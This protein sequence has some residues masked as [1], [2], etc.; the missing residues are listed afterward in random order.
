[1]KPINPSPSEP[2][3]I[4]PPATRHLTAT[5]PRFS[6]CLDGWWRMEGGARALVS[7]ASTPIR[8]SPLR[9]TIVNKSKFITSIN[10][11]KQKQGGTIGY[12]IHGLSLSYRPGLVLFFVHKFLVLCV[13]TAFTHGQNSS[14]IVMAVIF[15]PDYYCTTICVYLSSHVRIRFRFPLRETMTCIDRAFAEHQEGVIRPLSLGKR[16]LRIFNKRRCF[17]GADSRESL[18]Q[19]LTW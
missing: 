19:V 5:R 2:E 1:M 16:C 12:Y 6:A 14:R 13:G 8:A 17:F 15:F 7:L 3:A 9:R 11:A 18:Q 4:H 10:L